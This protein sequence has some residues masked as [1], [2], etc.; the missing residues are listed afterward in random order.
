MHIAVYSPVFVRPT[1]T[2]VYDTTTALAASGV[3]VSVLAA[4]REMADQRPF[5]PVYLVP[6]PGKLNPR[7]VV[8]R[9]LRPFLGR[10]PG[11]EQQAV[12]RNAIRRHLQRISP[13]VILATYGPS[14]VLLG[15]L[16][17]ELNIPM[18]VSFHGVDA[19]SLAR[20]PAWR[21]RYRELFQIASAVTGPSNYV[22]NKLIDL[23]C[24]EDR[25]YVLHNGIRTDRIRFSPPVKRFDRK[26]IRFLFVGR[27]TEKKDP[28]TLLRSFA[29]AQK[30]LLP[31]KIKLTIAGD[32]PLRAEVESEITALRIADSV[33]LLGRRTHDEVIQ[34]YQSAHIYAQHS[35]TAPNGD[36]EGL[37]VSITEALAAG[38]PVV[39]TRH[40]GIPEVVIDGK[41]GLLVDEKDTQGMAEAMVKL[42]RDPAQWDLFGAA[43]RKILESEFSL[44][45]VQDKLRQLL[46]SVLI[47]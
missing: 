34:L 1:E 36:E 25:A 14:G 26:E 18:I 30:S 17:Q 10:P 8:R 12:Q 16:A 19:S 7:R 3:R 21:R 28:I 47:T 29:R 20:D 11:G 15:P 35:A 37:P 40:S 24:P 39:S 42:A 43:G 27:L 33:N 5:Q 38:L 46:K 22:R 45:V 32:G 6:S 4:A 41:S 31:T 44:P 23:G 9:I 13:D 2:F